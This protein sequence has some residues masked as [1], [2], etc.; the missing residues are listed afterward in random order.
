M[1]K[2]IENFLSDEECLKYINN[3]N[4]SINTEKQIYFS[5]SAGSVNHKYKNLDLANFFYERA[6]KMTNCNNDFI[7]PNDIIMWAKYYPGTEFG[8]HTD[9]G[10]YYDAK[11]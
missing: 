6:N 2:V 7:K 1:I 5:N 4:T 11:K 9:T 8:L 10:L 3:I